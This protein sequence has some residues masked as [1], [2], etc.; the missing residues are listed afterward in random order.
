MITE[1]EMFAD[2]TTAGDAGLR[3]C[4]R[5]GALVGGWSFQV[6]TGEHR[7]REWHAQMDA[8]LA[9]AVPRVP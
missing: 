9:A 5:C 1:D 3:Q 8:L 6:G 4:L 2:I 7:H